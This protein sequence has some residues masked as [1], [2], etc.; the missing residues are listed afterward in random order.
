MTCPRTPRKSIPGFLFCLFFC[1]LIGWPGTAFIASGQGQQNASQTGDEASLQ[2]AN[3]IFQEA[4]QLWRAGKLKDAFPLAEQALRMREKVLGPDHPDIAQALNLLGTLYLQTKGDIPG[5]QALHQRA[6]K[7]RETALGPNH[8]SVAESLNALAILS[9]QKG[10][11]ENAEPLYRRALQIRET[12]LGPDHPDVAN[13]LN[14]LAVLYR[15]TGDFAKAEEHYLRAL[16]IREKSLKPDHPDIAQ[17]LSN[18]AVLYHDRGEYARAE[19]L[20]QR[21]LAI[22]EQALGPTHPDVAFSLNSIGNLRGDQGDLAAAEPLHLRALQIR[23]QALTPNHPDIAV[24]LNNLAIIS[25]EKGDYVKAEAYNLRALEIREKAFGPDNPMVA[26]S[27]NNLASLYQVKQDLEKAEA[28]H[29]RALK[30]R[31]KRL[32]PTHPDVAFSLNN[33]GIL[34]V[35]KGDNAQAEAALLRSLEIREKSLGPNHPVV[36]QSLTNLSNYY[37][38]IGKMDKAEEL[39]IRAES[40]YEKALGPENANLAPSFEI[41]ANLAFQRGDLKET[42]A[43]YRRALAIYEKSSGVNHPNTAHLLDRLARIH[44]AKGE[45]KEAID[46]QARAISASE[47]NLALNILGG[48]ARQ[49]A[50]FLSIFLD[51]TY[52]TISLHQQYAPTDARAG[53]IALTSLLQRKGRDLETLSDATLR[54]RRRADPNDRERFDRYTRTVS[55]IATLT[56][57]GMESQNASAFRTRI[58]ALEEEKEKIESELSQH[59][60]GLFDS[61]KP[62]SIEAV[63]RAIPENAALVEFVSYRPFDART[64]ERGKARYAAYLLFAQ[65]DP[66]WTDLGD[67]AVIDQSIAR[68]RTAINN[69]R[70]A[71][72]RKRARALDQQ[73]MQPLR[74]LLGNVRNVLLAPDGS[75]HLVPFAALLDEQ[76][77]YLAERFSFTYLSSGRDLLRAQNEP[78]AAGKP[79]IVANP[80]FGEKPAVRKEATRA[81]VFD[82]TE[83]Y[84]TPLKA[85]AQEAK[86]LNTLLPEATVLTG[87]QATESAI[88]QMAA[89]RL[90]H[91]ATHGFFLADKPVEDV[92]AEQ[93]RKLL[94]QMGGP[95]SLGSEFDNPLLR[96]GL[97]LAGA[98][99]RKSGPNREDDGILTA[100][101]VAGMDLSGTKLVVLSACETGVGEVRTGEGVYGL[102]RALVLAGAETQVMSLWPVSDRATRDLMIGYYKRL[103]AGEGR[104]EAMRKVQLQMLKDPR[105]R[106]PFYWASFIVSG[107]WA[108]LGEKK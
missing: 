16:A 84:F 108:S 107:E 63:Q 91:I 44:A 76:T 29:E 68:F 23:E 39:A 46:L 52:Q 27:L 6:L 7:I 9:R 54:L 43:L 14:N 15:T 78:M 32:G 58:R 97:G 28:M 74:Q 72:V 26:Y 73:I 95:L 22:R 4:N 59:S 36:A 69:P 24:T 56:F 47:Q 106:H 100:L 35:S 18:L 65:G 50:A 57:R 102:R 60:A 21:A 38:R 8:T 83:A 75:L 93:R 87:A 40:I 79:V 99:L 90:L 3:K 64:D 20:Y 45:L 96:S 31:E 53:R 70:S 80:D 17:S 25:Y 86:A 51:E 103:Q 34:Y 55:Q 67:A 5:A 37:K 92:G 10:E 101:E 71:D 66:K 82:L 49:K 94:Q 33:L 42:E 12:N 41:R 98:N 30:I 1:L 85:T 89:P 77:R 11:Y 48:S 62:V 61:L 105:R 19:P 104:S 88:K 13:T 2:Q 81:G